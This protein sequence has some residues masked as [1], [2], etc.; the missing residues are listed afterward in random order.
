MC[1]TKYAVTAITPA[2]V[3]GRIFLSFLVAARSTSAALA[4]LLPGLA[5]EQK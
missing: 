2:T 1:S 3:V 5:R 4:E